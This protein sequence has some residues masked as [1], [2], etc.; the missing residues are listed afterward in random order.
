MRISAPVTLI[1]M[2][3]PLLCHCG[4]GSSSISSAGASNPGY[5]PFDRKGNYVEE[6]A[7]KPAKKHSWAT[8]SV[9]TPPKEEPVIAS[10]SPSPT[11]PISRPATSTPVASLSRPTT[12]RPTVAPTP[13]KPKPTTVRPPAKPPRRHTVVRGDTLYNLS[14]RYGTSIGSIQR[15]NGI[16]GSTIRIGQRLLIPR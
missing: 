3:T 1:A 14:R 7:D 10:T 16:K 12:P 11:R 6:W 13:P 5:G 8:K 2:I 4:S 9:P 15:A